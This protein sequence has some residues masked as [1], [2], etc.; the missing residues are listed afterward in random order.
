MQV[1]DVAAD[2]IPQRRLTG[3]RWTSHVFEGLVCVEDEGGFGFV[4]TDN[5]PVIAS[6]FTWAATSAK[7]APRSRRPAAWG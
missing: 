2:Y 7:D 6:R 5:N 4:D 1:S 3:H